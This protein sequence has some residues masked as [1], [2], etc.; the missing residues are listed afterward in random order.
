MGS[1]WDRGP[2][3]IR[4]AWLINFSSIIDLGV[5]KDLRKENTEQDLEIWL[6]AEQQYHVGGEGGR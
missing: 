5:K 2:L 4:A 1:I 3:S 6:F